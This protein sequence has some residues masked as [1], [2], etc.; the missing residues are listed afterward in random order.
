[1]NQSAEPQGAWTDFDRA[2]MAR[3]LS[4][5]RRGLYTTDPNPRVGCVLVH[6]GQIVGEGWHERAG[7][8]HAEPNA[9]AA[10]GA[11]ARGATAYVSLEPC[12]H[13]GRTPPCAEALVAAGVARVIYALKDPNPRVSGAGEQRLREAGI[14]VAGGLMADASR[15]LNCGYVR[16]MSTGLPFVR[17]KLAMSLDGRTALA[18]GQ[19]RWITADAA[20][21]DVQYLRARSSAVLT[22]IGTV[23][24]DD[25]AMNVRIPESD[26]QPW[27]VVLDSTLRT[28]PESRLVTGAGPVLILATRDDAARRAALEGRSAA[29]EILPAAPA[30]VSLE[31]VLQRLGRLEMNEV[32]VEAGP[33][34]AG[35][36]VQAGLFDELIVYVAPALLGGDA[37]PL[38]ELPSISSLEQKVKL[39][40]TDF[41]AVGVDLRLTL[42]PA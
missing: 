40:F 42:R 30:G 39:A 34:L 32:W 35:A 16:R 37:L 28:P 9:L 31:A 23:L 25:P 10:A 14:D 1:M 3:A 5:A 18:N 29:V 21:N 8:P 2:M 33:G 20:R 27:R 26:R 17:V 22:G 36:F 41:R 12:S 38:L 6:G 4:L 7:A 15:Q 19:S 13:H 24:A 11:R